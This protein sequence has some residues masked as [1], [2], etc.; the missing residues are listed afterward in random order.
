MSA[1]AVSPPICFGCKHYD[2]DTDQCEVFGGP[3]PGPI[4]ENQADH[5]GPYPGDGGRTFVA[6]EPWAE[7]YA[8]NVFSDDEPPAAILALPELTFDPVD[9]DAARHADELF[10]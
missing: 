2:R 1:V 4:L 10:P 9:E 5:R 3:I 7:R 8:A 6:V